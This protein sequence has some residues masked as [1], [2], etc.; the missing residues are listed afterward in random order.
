MTP[1]EFIG[2]HWG[3][4]ASLLG[5]ALTIWFSFQA[6]TAAERARDSAQ[7]VKE[8][9]STLDTVGD[10][11]TAITMMHE[12]MRLQRTQAWDVVWDIVLERYAIIQSHLVRSGEGLGLTEPHRASIRLAVGQFRIIMGDIERARTSEQREQLDTVKFNRIVLDHA[13]AL[14]KIRTLVRAAG[15]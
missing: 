7:Q 6:K 13:A 10:L 12:I 11:S 14:E 4:L 3:D 15:A 5:L 1:L 8:R 2:K 9:I